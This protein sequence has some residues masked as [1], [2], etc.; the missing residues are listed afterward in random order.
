M[1]E[2]PLP[3]VPAAGAAG[4][5]VRP[6]DEGAAAEAPVCWLQGR[7]RGGG[8]RGSSSSRPG[9]APGPPVRLPAPGRVQCSL[10]GRTQHQQLPAH[11]GQLDVIPM[12]VM[13]LNMCTQRESVCCLKL[14]KCFLLCS[15]FVNP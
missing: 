9:P 3:A 7:G 10:P 15:S 13:L 6:G 14:I 4:P 2:G 1:R 11:S 5:R 12:P 8:V